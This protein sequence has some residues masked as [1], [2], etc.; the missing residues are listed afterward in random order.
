MKRSLN[1][2]SL[3]RFQCLRLSVDQ[4]K[5]VLVSNPKPLSDQGLIY[6]SGTTKEAA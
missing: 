4:A 3:P 2:T 1:L 6:L 5:V